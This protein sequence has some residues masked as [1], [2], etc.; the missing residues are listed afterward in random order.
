M[1]HDKRL[2]AEGPESQEPFSRAHRAVITPSYLG[3]LLQTGNACFHSHTPTFHENPVFFRAAQ[4]LC[5]WLSS[6]TQ[7][8]GHR[9]SDFSS[10]HQRFPLPLFQQVSHSTCPLRLL[11]PHTQASVPSAHCF[12]SP[13]FCPPHVAGDKQREI[14]LASCAI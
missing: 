12:P 11:H 7:L 6:P 14:P 4:G 10:G 9:T 3:K 13:V 2:W 1:K 8:S 5:Q